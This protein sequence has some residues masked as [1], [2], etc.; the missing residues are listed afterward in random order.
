L[1][2]LARSY[3]PSVFGGLVKIRISFSGS[4]L[5]GDLTHS[6]F[7]FL[8]SAGVRLRKVTLVGFGVLGPS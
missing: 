6:F 4:N 2:R 7:Q 5:R 8:I 1:I 3:H